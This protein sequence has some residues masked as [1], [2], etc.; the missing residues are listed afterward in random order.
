[1]ALINTVPPD[2]ASGAIKEGYDMFLKNV[3]II[4]RPMEVLSCSPA[5]FSLQLQRIRYFAKHPKLSFSLLTHIRYLVSRNLDYGFCVDFNKHLLKK[6]GMEEEDIRK[7]EQDPSQ[8]LLEEH[9][10]A[11]LGFVVKAVKAPGSVTAGDISRLRALGWEDG[12][13]V[14]ALAQGVGMIDHSI[15]MQAFQVDQNC[16]VG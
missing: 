1:M 3:G 5:L 14:D 16:M 7:M 10:N 15:M 6:Q 9:E 11:M 8:S 13:M 2:K 12:D 4:P